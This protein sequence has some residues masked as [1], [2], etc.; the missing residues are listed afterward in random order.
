MTKNLILPI[1]TTENDTEVARCFAENFRSV[2]IIDDGCV[3]E[4]LGH[5]SSG[6]NNIQPDVIMNEFGVFAFLKSLNHQ[7][8][9]DLHNHCTYADFDF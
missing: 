9:C 3:L 5:D 6:L 1:Y 2:F 4:V 8:G 7:K